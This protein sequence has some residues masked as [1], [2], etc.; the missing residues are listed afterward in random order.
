MEAFSML[1]AFCAGN[2]PVPGEFPAQRPVTR[3]F[4][5]FFDL[6]PNKRLSKQSWGWWMETP[7]CSL[8]HHRN[9]DVSYILCLIFYKKWCLHNGL[10]LWCWN[11]S[12]PLHW[13]H[14]CEVISNHQRFDCLLNCLFKSRSKKTSKLH[15][16]GLYEF[17][18]QR[19]S[20]AE[21]VSIW[22]RH[23]ARITRAIPPGLTGPWLSQGR[24]STTFASPVL[25]K[26]RKYY[27]AV[28]LQRGLFSHKHSQKTP[29]SSPARVR[30]GV[31]FVDWASDWYS[32][33]VP[34]IVYVI[35]YDITPRYNGTRL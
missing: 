2:S 17:P 20:N 28:P 1:L 29:H 5:A 33:S 35:S 30:Y 3:S 26:N 21:N 13:R 11:Q 27:S 6:R 19:V 32:A 18:A 25:R 23:H 7:W 15:V 9:A 14:D 34:V 22:W 24:I 31:S 8:W 10:S 16:S 12:I 4:D